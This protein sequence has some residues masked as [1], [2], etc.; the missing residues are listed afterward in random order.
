MHAFACHAAAKFLVHNHALQ[1]LLLHLPDC[2]KAI[3]EESRPWRVME[4]EDLY[5][6]V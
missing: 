2:L 1:G 5:D 3:P 4:A 6:T